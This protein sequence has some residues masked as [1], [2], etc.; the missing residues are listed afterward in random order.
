[1]YGYGRV[2]VSD[3][4]VFIYLLMEIMY[5]PLAIAM[6]WATIVDKVASH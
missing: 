5:I 2:G 4:S 1:M 3:T 6:G